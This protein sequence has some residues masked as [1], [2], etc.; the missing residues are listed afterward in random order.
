LYRLPDVLKAETVYIVEGEKDTDRLW[1]LG[2]PATTNPHGAKKWREEY[3]QP[4]AGKQ[5]V[6]LPDNDKPGEQHTLQ[7]ARFTI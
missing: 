5:M 1:S 2:I 3:N 7:V 4:L 6:I